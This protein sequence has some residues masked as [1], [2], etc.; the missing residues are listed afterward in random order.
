[1]S[2][3]GRELELIVEKLESIGLPK[4]AVIKSPDSIPHNI[5]G[6]GRE[7][8]VS[9]RYNIGNNSIL[10]IIE[11]RDRKSANEDITW[12]EQVKSKREG[13]NADKFIAVSSKGFSKNAIKYASTYGIETRTIEELTKENLKDFPSGNAIVNINKAEFL[14]LKINKNV[15]SKGLEKQGIK[16]KKINKSYLGHTHDKDYIIE[17]EDYDFNLK[18]HLWFLMQAG[19][20]A[21]FPDLK[22][23]NDGT[24]CRLKFTIN[25]D[26]KGYKIRINNPKFKELHNSIIYDYYFDVILWNESSKM[27]VSKITNYNG[28]DK[29]I[30][31]SIE[32]T[33][34]F[35]GTERKV[36]QHLD[37]MNGKRYIEDLA[38]PEHFKI[39][40]IPKDKDSISDS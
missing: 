20:K 11:C 27:P 31:Q 16:F 25:Y 9:I 6:D 33:K 17:L 21:N 15:L 29:K 8:D 4:D 30:K 39:E 40:A 7:V 13:I 18:V 38:T 24:K 36:I 34:I 1:M 12:M 10:I 35:D 14:D 32:Y 5:T 28:E 3:K 23:P 22:I 26:N 19:I 37:F 2:R